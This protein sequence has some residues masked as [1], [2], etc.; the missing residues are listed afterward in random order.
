[1][2][3]KPKIG[4]V[5][6]VGGG[7]AGMQASLDAAAVGYK[8][9]L[10][11]RDISIGGVMAQLDKTFPTNDCSTCLISPKLIEVARHPDIEIITQAELEA[12]EGEAGH[13]T[14]TLQQQPRYI[15]ASRCNACGAC[16]EACPVEAPSSFDEGLGKR[17]A[18]YRHFPQA[19]PSTFAIKKY[20]RAPCVRACPANLSA[21]GYVQLIKTGKFP[22]ALNLI[23]DRLPLPGTIGRICPHPCETDCRRQ[24]VD[25]PV[26]ICALKRFVADQVDWDAL[27]VPEIPQQGRAAA[28]VGSG[29]SG[30]SC[31]Y[32]L[33]LMGYRTV[34]FEAAPDPGGWLR[35][36]IPEYRLPREVLD[37]EINYIKRL[38]VE[39]RCHSPIGPGRSIDEL[40]TRDGF[41]AVFIGVGAQ[42]SMRLPV[43]GTDAQGVLW[44]VEYL[45][46]SALGNK[47]DLQGQKVAVIGGGNVAMDVAR[48]SKRQG[49]DV[50]L[51]CLES[52]EEMPASPWEVEEAEAEG[53]PLV[54]RWG[55]KQILSAAGKVTGIELK[56]VA[57]VFD[58]Q[59]RFSPVYHEDQTAIREA[60]MVIMAI[61]Q[62][63]DVKFLADADGIAL[64]P[65][66]LIA[67]DP[68]T[69]ATSREGVFAGG[70]A[71]T[72]PFIAIAAVAAGREAA[73]SIDRYL[74]GVDLNAD[75]ELPLRPIRDGNW[76]PIDANLGKE[77]R[78]PMPH[79]P[80][81][82]WTQGF[83]EINLGLTPEEARREAARCV[84]CGLCSECLQCVAACQAGAID[85]AQK[86][87]TRQLEVGALILAP[88]FRIFDARLKPEY[89]YGRYPNV[90]TGLEFERILS[91]TGPCMGHV[92]RP[93]DGAAP[94][95]VAWIQCVGSR[96]PSIGREYCSYACCMYATKQAI[97]AK[98][99]DHNIEP[100]I[101]YIDLRAQ[102]KGFDRYC[103]RAKEHHGVRFV[104]SMISRVAQDPRT[105]DLELT[106]VDEE[107]RIRT[108][109]FQMV[110]L[111]V[112]FGP[113]AATRELAEKCGIALNRW[114]FA[115]NPPLEMVSSSRAGIYTCGAFQAPKDI[116][117][118]VSQASAA[119]GAAASLLAE[120]RGTLV[121]RAEYPPE[122][123]ISQEE[124]RIGVFVCHCG[125]NIAGVVDVA[126]VS[127][128]A[129][130][131][132]GV[133]YADHFTFTCA[134][135]SLEKM[136]EVI[137][138]QGL[139]RVVVASCS[140]RTHEPLFQ[141]N[142]RKA[143]LNKYLF[144][145]A[146][147]RDQDSW[148]HRG[149]PALATA[150]ARELVKMAVGRA[151]LLEP[152]SELPFQVT[153]SA[154]VVGN[155]LAA[156]TASLTIA[157]AGYQVHLAALE[158]RYGF[159]GLAHKLHY[160]LEGYDIQAYI[161]ETF[162]KVDEHP[163]I[164]WWPQTR[165]VSFSGH[166]GKF[167]SMLEYSGQ[168]RELAYGALI[169]ATG[170]V[171]Y[172]P[173]EYLYGQHPRVFTLMEL[174]NLLVTQ[175]EILGES[176]KVVMIQ[177]VG[178]REPEHP[179]CSRQCCSKAVKNAI[180]I[181]E[182]NPQ[183]QVFIL[184]RDIRTFGLKEI[185]YQKARELG[186]QFIRFDPERKPEVSAAG[187]GLK[188]K[189]FDQNLRATLELDANCL[190]LA[191]AI[192]PHPLSRDIAQIFKLPF[193]A[194]GFF[195]E[196]HSKLRP[197]DFAASGIF[198]CGLAHSPKFFEESIAQA[199][200][201]AARA[202]GI[203]AQ[204][205]MYVG[206]AVAAVDPLKCIICLTCM[207]TCP[208][209]VPRVNQA[210][211]VIEIDPAACKGCGNCASACPRKAID[212]MHHRDRQ[213]A[214]KIGAIEEEGLLAI[215][216]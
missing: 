63:T 201:A 207:R 36:G 163:R 205:E 192:R 7:I 12:L 67:A 20:D 189:V 66:G 49:G 28:I 97:I 182:T 139:N 168:R 195:M 162:R 130:S 183:A 196:A 214:A 114:G 83:Q 108:E 94:K 179:Y 170:G 45:K 153:Q 103:E 89:G 105:N 175:P 3:D 33:A 145:M 1:M 27:P 14:A 76:N 133:A 212:V 30:L 159:G 112:G 118:T 160:T 85:H 11:E 125:I 115:Q 4:A 15:D 156:L 47:P 71:V 88:G 98:E 53:I 126:A 146:N 171:D 39:I 194:D 200:G 59:G 198:L 61:G 149:E 174:D 82:Q 16:A 46:D 202:L 148:V 210:A 121:T 166:I 69:L 211:G 124:P 44:G 62:K 80:Q 117:E 197:L 123:G 178:S 185:Y 99:H 52:R 141:D 18:A 188:I 42:E 142:L 38:G 24:E 208:F 167:R 74:R 158:D 29:P 154:L 127:E 203:L 90:I 135:D 173:D 215:S 191:A 169:I 137:E 213:F 147:I 41:E 2:P 87:R 216:C 40:L 128:Y 161:Q 155:G 70:D 91:A 193:D 95:K 37:R 138:A 72:G 134:T 187:E 209:G 19:V 176:P 6:V 199:Q 73:I 150:K 75:R 58:D 32:H 144:E 206:G 77:S 9:Y 113:H 22:E 151:A 122:R 68:E 186:V 181:K 184:Y 10:V 21:Q 65:R 152:L 60:D 96:D 119:A 64:T 51:I 26:A 136:R 25:E 79:L 120:A 104:R 157:N 110:V 131:L 84:N 86:P 164:R 48:T 116:P 165:V 140:P 78:A 50:T 111:S 177:C 57:R 35:Y 190:G 23:M 106:Y 31:A 34:I 107:D 17:R 100:A 5:M 129:R 43:P 55:V 81:A 93:S 13:F 204:K 143:G 180:K 56:A 8:V 92:T 172:K 102:G 109:V 132:P 101:F 54:T